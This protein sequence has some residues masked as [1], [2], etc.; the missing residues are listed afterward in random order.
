MNNKSL[1]SQR[2][3][4]KYRLGIVATLFLFATILLQT[5]LAPASFA[6]SITTPTNVQI[7]Q[8]DRAAV[9][10][11]DEKD[12]DGN[13]LTVAGYKVSWGL[14]G[15]SVKNVQLTAYKVI[16]L[17][18]LVNGQKYQV[19]I[20]AEGYDGTLSDPSPIVNFTGDSSRV[21]ALRKQMTGFFDDFNTP[22][23]PPDELKWNQAYSACDDPAISAM[24]VNDQYHVH[25]MISTK[26]CDRG[27]AISRPRAVFDFTNR[28]GAITFDFDGAFRR[29]QWYL[30]LVPQLMDITGQVSLSDGS[31]DYPT[32]FLRIH[33]SQ[34]ALDIMYVNAQG[35][36]TTV[37][38][39]DY[40]PYPPLDD[41]GVK[42]VSNVRRHWEIKVS[43]TVVTIIIN[44]K[45][46]LSTNK[47]KLPYSKA[48]V[49]WNAFSYNTPKSNEPDA[50]MHWDNFGFDG[51]APT[52]VTHNYRATGDGQSDFNELGQ[53]SASY[54]ITM[55]D[56]IKGAT[57]ARLM[58]TMQTR[59]DWYK[60]DPD[61]KVIVN[62]QSFPIQ[63][64][65][66][67]NGNVGPYTPFS[68]YINLPINLVK[69]GINEVQF[70]MGS[71]GILNVHLELDFPKNSAPNYTPPSKIFPAYSAMAAMPSA[72]PGA[73]ID[74]WDNV[75]VPRLDN[76]NYTVSKTVA[77]QFE[78]GE[79]IALSSTGHNPGIAK[80][81]LR[82]NQQPIYT[83]NLKNVPSYRGVFNFDTTK[84][85]NGDYNLDIVAYDSLG[86]V[87][88]PDYFEAATKA[89]QYAP[90]KI[91][92]HNTNSGSIGV[93]PASNP[94]TDLPTAAPTMSPDMPM[95]MPMP[96][97]EAT[98]VNQVAAKPAPITNSLL[99]SENIKLMTLVAVIL[100]IGIGLGVAS[101][102]YIGSVRRKH[103]LKR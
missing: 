93:A 41:A 35:V 28:T 98:T 24:F 64:A 65:D 53:S 87:S 101:T 55:P 85:K 66:K 70:Q 8:D 38:T 45:T 22:A 16:E 10:S 51:P 2:I 103:S 52:T 18:P 13:D 67:V 23:G 14:A 58:F 17:Q 69:T 75:S 48:Y 95:N 3:L 46:V 30:D 49:L 78:V 62:G 83:L 34:Q 63:D 50:L 68:T 40:N 59:N 92:I 4:C 60:Y 37:A 47:L 72:G 15:Q 12:A 80:I 57:A 89:G 61:D 97:A 7:D 77:V 33:Q 90:I 1:F 76:T 99:T 71:S 86:Q 100:L 82:L 74:G 31:K 79:D 81:E 21:D 32:N 5:L 43:Q 84:Y 42:L 6:D 36:E 94:N 25:N 54:H 91:T 19:Q 44:G 29:D 96:T 88:I 27:Q 73:V 20:Q 11:W 102:L 56:S 26:T 9:V 39:T